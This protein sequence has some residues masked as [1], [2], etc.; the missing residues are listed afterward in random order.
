MQLIWVSGPVGTIRRVNL[1]AKTLLLFAAAAGLAFILIGFILEFAGFRIAIEYDP[2]LV[3]RMGNFYSEA[4]LSGLKRKYQERM[5][6]VE[7]ELAAFNSRVQDLD[8]LNRRLK[9]IATPPPLISR[10]S[11][12]DAMGGPLIPLPAPGGDLIGRIDGVR[13]NESELIKY[14]D[15]SIDYWKNQVGWLESKPILLPLQGDITITSRYGARTD[16]FVNRASF[17]PGLDFQGS[18]GS[19]VFATASGLVEYAG[20]DSGYGNCV[21]IDHGDGYKTRY[22]HL[23]RLFVK[24]GQMVD[25]HQRIGD[26][27]STGRSTG[28]HLHYEIIKDG[29]TIDPETMLV[30]LAR[31]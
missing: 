25:Q 17:H 5:E 31:R 6:S 21:V 24:T 18:V 2:H 7:R 11:K 9:R 13:Q 28:P 26:V 15:Q 4:E 12:P 30:R 10:Q 19:V 1:T 14:A 3:H 27:G 29:R 8:A 22:A 20:W 23:S 16:P